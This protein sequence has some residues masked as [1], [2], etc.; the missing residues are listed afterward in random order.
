MSSHK[1]IGMALSLAA[2]GGGLSAY[3]ACVNGHPSV[4]KEYAAS[5][6]VVVANVVGMR[7][8]PALKDGV[9][10]EGTMYRVAVERTYHGRIDKAPEIFSENSSGRFPMRLG[11]T[12]L[13]FIF[14]EH[15]RL[16]VDYCGNSGLLSD[17]AKELKEI[18]QLTARR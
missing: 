8:V 12:Y 4:P 15:G 16:L 6:A 1:C 2:F 13:L 11:A 17:R 7:S 14:A 9:F 10:L 18:E 5:R 3:G